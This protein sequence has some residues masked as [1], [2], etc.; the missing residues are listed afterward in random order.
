MTYLF[1]WIKKN[2]DFSE[3]LIHTNF[4]KLCF[5]E[6]TSV[7]WGGYSQ[8]NAELLLLKC[9]IKE[10]YKY[11]HLLSGE[12]LP[13]KTPKEIQGF[14]NSYDGAIF[15]DFMSKEFDNYDRVKYY[16]FFQ[17]Y[18]GRKFNILP[19]RILLKL[20]RILHI[21]RNKGIIWGK[22]ANWFSI[23]HYFAQYVIDHEKWIKKVFKNTLIGDEV[24]IQTILLNSIYY[25]R[26]WYKEFDDNPKSIMREIDWKRGSPYIYRINDLPM[27]LSSDRM[28][29]RKF[30]CKV[31]NRIIKA[32][33]NHL[34]R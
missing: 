21:H 30:D 4:S 20:Q 31:D 5:S 13:I 28:F 14:F 10:E 27:L 11:Y 32:I 6:R 2:V 23:P 25:D 29:A 9:A 16:H 34:K 12:D 26:L 33:K 3:S 15:I 22:G 8:I 24:F 17:E 18:L 1:I 7:T 19:N